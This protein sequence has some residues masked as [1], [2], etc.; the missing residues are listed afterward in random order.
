MKKNVILSYGVHKASRI[1]KIS[2]DFDYDL[3][4][5]LKS[6]HCYW[7]QNLKTWYVPYQEEK[8]TAFITKLKTIAFV[9]DRLLATD[10]HQKKQPTRDLKARLIY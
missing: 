2:F 5:K 9:D 6:M 8:I 1:V 7:S 4:E 3:K 10:L